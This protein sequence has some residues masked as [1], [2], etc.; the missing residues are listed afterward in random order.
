[1]FVVF[2]DLTEGLERLSEETR[3]G[4]EEHDIKPYKSRIAVKDSVVLQLP[5]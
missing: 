5:V 1:V 4:V 3:G 2:A